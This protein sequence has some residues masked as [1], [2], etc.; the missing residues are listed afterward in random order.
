MELRFAQRARATKDL[1]LG[2]QGNRAARL[3]E[4][5]Q[6]LIAELGQDCVAGAGAAHWD[7][8]PGQCVD[9]CSNRRA[10]SN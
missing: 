10:R 8:A 4:F 6:A 5:A 7:T 9:G 1:D 3:R 2:L